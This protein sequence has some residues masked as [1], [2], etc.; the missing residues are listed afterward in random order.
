METLGRNFL[1]PLPRLAEDFQKELRSFQD[2]DPHSDPPPRAKLCHYVLSSAK[3]KRPFESAMILLVGS[4]GVGKSS[5]INHLF[6]TGVGLPVAM[7]SAAESETK[8]TSE[9]VLTVDEPGFEVS[10]LKMS[11]IDTPGFN[12]TDGLKQDACNFVSI[13]RFFETHPSL[14]EQFTYPNLVFLVVNAMDPRIKGPRSN[15]SKGLKAIELL[16]V[17]DSNF[18]TW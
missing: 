2:L 11:I 6:D 12:D 5:T 1:P 18:L 17:V 16:K 7:T 15:L 3:M 10:D 4:S 8:A 14:P 13:K 9:Y